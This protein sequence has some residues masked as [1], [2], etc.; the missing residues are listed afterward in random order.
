MSQILTPLDGGRSEIQT[1]NNPVRGVFISGQYRQAKNLNPSPTEWL[2]SGRPIYDRLPAISERYRVNFGFNEDSAY[3]YLPV[4][5]SI[6][7][8]N[9]LG[10]ATSGENKFIVIKG[11][12]IVWKHGEFKID[13]TIINVEKIG[14]GNTRYLLAYQLY[15]DDSPF[16]GLYQVTDYRLKGLPLSLTSNTDNVSGWRYLPQYALYGETSL[17]WRNYDT[18]FPSYS[19]PAKLTLTFTEAPSFTKIL[20]R[21]PANTNI[22]GTAELSVASEVSGP[23]ERVTSVGVQ[24]DSDG[25]FFEFNLDLNNFA[26]VW[27]VEWSDAKVAINDVAVSGII[28]L[29]RKPEE[30]L[31]KVSL[32]AY[33][34]GNLPEKVTNSAGEEVQA[35]YCKLAFV[36]IDDSST[37]T[38][39]VDLRESVNSEYTPISDWLTRAWDSNLMDLHNQVENY[40]TMW[41]GPKECLKHEYLELEDDLIKVE[42]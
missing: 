24:S 30:G 6:F 33:P 3:V 28:S 22:T 5:N 13:P 8:P 11:G 19:E 18:V 16:N 36:D 12:T 17:E 14:F 7:G 2:T 9:S 38:N 10:V 34:Q 37:V 39:I 35:T 21:C 23:Y 25:Q 26:K 41:M 27:S 40:S 4:G 29:K 31:T 42:P 32:V 1:S 20:F 15:L